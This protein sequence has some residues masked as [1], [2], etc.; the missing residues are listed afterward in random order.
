MNDYAD[1]TGYWQQA[2]NLQLASYNSAY[3][4]LFNSG[5]SLAGGGQ[6]IDGGSNYAPARLPQLAPVEATPETPELWLR[7]RVKETCWFA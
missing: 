3:Q 5:G 4:G 1:M 6:Y 2:Q 7:R